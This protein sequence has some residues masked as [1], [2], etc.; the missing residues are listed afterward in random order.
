VTLNYIRNM[1][2]PDTK[3]TGMIAEQSVKGY[4]TYREDGYCGHEHLPELNLLNMNA[5]LYDPLT[6]RFLSPDPYVQL[7]D[8]TQSFNRYS[9]CLNNPLKLMDLTGKRFDYSSMSG[10]EYANYVANINVLLNNRLF[11][12][13]YNKLKES[14]DVVYHIKIDTNFERLEEYET[15]DALYV[16]TEKTI[17][18]G[19]TYSSW[20][21]SEEFYHAYQDYNNFLHAPYN[22]ELEA[23]F[24]AFLTMEGKGGAAYSSFENRYLDYCSNYKYGDISTDELITYDKIDVIIQDYL[25]IGQTF[26]YE[27]PDDK[28]YTVPVTSF[29]ELLLKTLISVYKNR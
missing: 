10:K 17:F 28:H 23:N 29:P 11:R 21:L 3:Y 12:Y 27:R 22:I 4:L 13:Y 20:A 24:V 6:A 19:P 9:Y 5:R 7:P 8:F 15:N 14:D 16:D 1:T 26:I 2:G 25:D 18:L